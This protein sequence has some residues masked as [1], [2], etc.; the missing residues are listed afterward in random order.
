MGRIISL[1]CFYSFLLLAFIFYYYRVSFLY[2]ILTFC[3]FLIPSYYLT[4]PT[5]KK[6]IYIFEGKKIKYTFFKK[7]QSHID[8]YDVVLSNLNISWHLPA[9]SGKIIASRHP[10]H[11]VDNEVRKLDLKKFF[12]SK[13]SCIEKEN[14]L[15]KYNVKYLLLTQK[16]IAKLTKKINTCGFVDK[17]ILTCKNRSLIRVKNCYP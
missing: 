14:I 2:A 5:L 4:L 10:V 15:H 3:I 16:E 11:W 13:T 17:I 9:F 6:T 12:S 7:V 8:H 1:L